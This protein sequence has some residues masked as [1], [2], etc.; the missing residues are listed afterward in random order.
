MNQVDDIMQGGQD[1]AGA[2][3]LAV[4]AKRPPYYAVYQTDLRV[5]V[6]FSDDPAVE[7]QQRTALA[8]LSPLREDINSLIDGWRKHKGSRNWARALRFDRSVAAALIEG[9]EE[10]TDSG[11]ALL[12]ETKDQI[13]GERTS[14]AQFQYLLIAAA[15]SILLIALFSGINRFASLP[16]PADRLLL[17]AGAGCIGAFFSIAIAIHTRT[18]LIDLLFWNNSMDAL[19]R[20]CIGAISGA[21]LVGLLCEKAVEF[22]LGSGTFSLDD[23]GPW[24]LPALAGFVAGFSERLTGDFIARAETVVGGTGDK[25]EASPS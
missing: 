23:S 20:I 13:V 2:T 10:D 14:V 6:H 3:I 9:L 18:V 21:V 11:A 5:Q 12:K 16:I 1:P 22:S 15:A 19:L 7:E 8:K 24:L 17:A 25:K 4:Y